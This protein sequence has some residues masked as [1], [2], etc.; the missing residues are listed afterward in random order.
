VR[1]FFVAVKRPAQRWQIRLETRR[2]GRSATN[3]RAFPRERRRFL[4]LRSNLESISINPRGAAVD[5]WTSPRK[6]RKNEYGNGLFAKGSF[7]S[8]D[9]IFRRRSLAS[10]AMRDRGQDGTVR[11][12]LRERRSHSWRARNVRENKLAELQASD[13]TPLLAGGESPLPS[14]P[15]G[16]PALN[17]HRD[18]SFSFRPVPSGDIA[19]V[20]IF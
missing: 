1:N 12:R 17:G 5:S 3:T 14:S 2:R 4:K 16:T 15:C 18:F 10:P 6:K 13:G 7:A 19:L 20:S 8:R 11:K 9:P